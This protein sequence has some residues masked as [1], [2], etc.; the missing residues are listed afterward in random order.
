[1]KKE[2]FYCEIAYFCLLNEPIELSSFGRLYLKTYFEHWGRVSGSFFNYV[3]IETIF[4]KS[5]LSVS[6]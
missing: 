3:Q 6:L 2:I 4:Q 1:M 5:A